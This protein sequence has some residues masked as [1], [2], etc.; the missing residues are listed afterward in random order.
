MP[1]QYGRDGT[2]WRVFA[3]TMIMLVGIF[4]FIDGIV[5]ILRPKYLYVSTGTGHQL[6]FGTIKPWGWA[7][8]ILGVIQVLVALAIYSRQSWAAV[9]GIIVAVLNGIGQLL[10]IETNPWWSIVAIALDVMVIYALAMYGF[11]PA[12][13]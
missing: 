4:N 3:A 12:T 6:V 10:Y 13:E 9:V 7:I 11:A 5:A 2:G 1:G 8:L